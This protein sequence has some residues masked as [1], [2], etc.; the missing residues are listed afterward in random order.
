MGSF[1]KNIYK[2]TTFCGV[3]V[4]IFA[5]TPH[6]VV[7]LLKLFAK[8]LHLVVFLHRKLVKSLKLWCLK[9]IIL[10]LPNVLGKTP[11]Y[12]VS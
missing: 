3:L 6:F 4:E 8:T 2:D 10:Y 11:R 5:R 7:S 12:V 9:Q 1:L